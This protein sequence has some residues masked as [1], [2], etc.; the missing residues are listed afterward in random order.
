MCVNFFFA[1]PS[2]PLAS[3]KRPIFNRYKAIP[4]K[5]NSCSN[6]KS[7]RNWTELSNFLRS[8][9]KE[10]NM[11]YDWRISDKAKFYSSA[12]YKCLKLS[13]ALL[14]N[15]ASFNVQRICSINSMNWQLRLDMRINS[16]LQIAKI[17]PNSCLFKI[18]FSE[19]IT[20]Y[21]FQ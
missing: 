15:I 9:K 21:F 3:R 12:C 18:F 4:Y 17:Y 8:K 11:N 7:K 20:K 5:R 13:Y 10:V 16:I 2:H 14:R 1:L 19:L 6:Y